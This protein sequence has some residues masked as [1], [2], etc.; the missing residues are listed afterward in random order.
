RRARMHCPTELASYLLMGPRAPRPHLASGHPPSQ[1]RSSL[2]TRCSE[3]IHHGHT[4]ATSSQS[5]QTE[6]ER[7]R[8]D[9]PPP[10]PYCLLPSACCFL[11]AV[12][13]LLFAVC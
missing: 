10:S 6:M 3:Q 8:A 7:R 5:R 2:A 13:C 9:L 11:R 12:C 1:T 4:C